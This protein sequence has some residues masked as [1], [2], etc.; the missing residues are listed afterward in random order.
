[1]VLVVAMVLLEP[2]SITTTCMSR[3][4]YPVAC[5]ACGLL[6]CHFQATSFH[7]HVGPSATALSMLVAIVYPQSSK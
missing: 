5:N 4:F 1:M 3:N 6:F 2:P 7:S